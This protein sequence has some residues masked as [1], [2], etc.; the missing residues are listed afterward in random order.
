VQAEINAI[1]ALNAIIPEIGHG[2]TVPNGQGPEPIVVKPID[3]GPVFHNQNTNF[4]IPAR[5][6]GGPVS[7]GQPYMVGERGPERFIPS[8]NG[9]I[10]PSG[11]GGPQVIQLVVDGRVLASIVND[12]NTKNMR[13]GRQLPAA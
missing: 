8:T 3:V 7:A 5:A 12:Y 2:P 9:T 1:N 10:L 6:S 11:S 4:T 13:R